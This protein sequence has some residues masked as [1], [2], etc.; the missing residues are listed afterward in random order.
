[1]KYRL[2]YLQVN[3]DELK[4][5]SKVFEANTDQQA[6]LLILGICR[7][8]ESGINNALPETPHIFTDFVVKPTKLIKIRQPGIT[9]E[10][11][12]WSSKG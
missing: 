2:D 4:W 12:V 10:T 1:M 3:K 8:I 6:I 9:E 5:D 7:D 11:V